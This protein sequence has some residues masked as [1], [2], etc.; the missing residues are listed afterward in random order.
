MDPD[1]LVFM[2][3]SAE[4]IRHLRAEVG[5]DSDVTDEPTTPAALVG[6]LST[7]YTDTAMGN[8]SVLRTALVV[9]RKR[10]MNLNTRSF[11]ATSGGRLLNRSQRIRYTER[12]IGELSQK[13]EYTLKGVNAEVQS[14]YQIEADSTSEF[15]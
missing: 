9:W 10:L 15:S 8:F 12:R 7:I 3:L 5:E 1:T 4:I 14:K 13:V 11:D 2:A 6:D